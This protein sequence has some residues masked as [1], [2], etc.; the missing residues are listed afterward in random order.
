MNNNR[1]IVPF[2]EY[3]H[4]TEKVQMLLQEYGWAGMVL[5]AESNVHYYSGFRNPSPWGSFTRPQFLFIPVVGAPVVY[6]HE[7]LSSEAAFR[8]PH[9]K[10]RSFLSL[11]GPTA[12]DLYKIMDELG[13]TRGIVG[14]EI[15]HEQRMNFQ[16]NRFIELRDM[17][18]NVK[19]E[20]A[21]K[22]IW[23]QRIIKSP[24]E[25]ECHR[26]ACAAVDYVF[27]HIFEQVC[28][29]M[30]EY[31][32]THMVRRMMLEGGADK[33]GF[34][35]ICSG[36]E[37]YERTGGISQDRCLQ[38]GDMLWLD[39]SCEY[40]GYWSDFCRA[41]I[42]G[43][44]DDE[45]KRMQEQVYLATQEAAELIRPGV[46]F[47][48]L[49]L[50]CG[51]GLEK[52]GYDVNYHIGRFGHFIEPIVRPL[53]FDWRIGVSLVT[54]IAAKEVIISTMA[55]FY[56]AE[57]NYNENDN[58]E[59]LIQKQTWKNGKYAGETIFSPLVAYGLMLFVLLCTPCIAALTAIKR[60][61]GL[62]W[63]V[64]SMIYSTGL[65]WIV[66]FLV[67]QIGSLIS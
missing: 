33:D 25:I 27:D 58:M 4:R 60:E 57:D 17:L 49:A 51:A 5:S 21:A 47:K 10:H 38:K 44:I 62:K 8:A 54:G 6:M 56:Q 67:Y 41:G 24:I 22:I 9:M 55:V 31:E 42:V 2:T 1:L 66:S 35:I 36:K 65:A 59:Q 28:E 39:L 18:V 48:D 40:E 34:V 61:A 20:D 16:V 29:G 50:A 45:C 63:A 43:S 7:L 13:M 32:I 15:G 26:K 37:N 64:F 53:G 52:R 23:K 30:N 12:K 19:I 46:S 11:L 3:K 14:F